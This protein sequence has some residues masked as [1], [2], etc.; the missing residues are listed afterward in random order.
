MLKKTTGGTQKSFKKLKTLNYPL[1]FHC[2]ILGINLLK[3]VIFFLKKAA[4]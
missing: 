3:L 4:K 1:D 2:D